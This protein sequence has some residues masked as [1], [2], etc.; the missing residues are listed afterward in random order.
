MNRQTSFQSCGQSGLPLAT[1][2]PDKLY[3]Y[4]LRRVW[5]SV[6]EPRVVTWVLLNPSTADEF[7]DDPTIRR[8]IG[9]SQT[10]HFDELMIVNAYAWRSTD[11]KGLRSP[12]C[13]A[14]GGPVGEGNDAAIAAAIDRSQL[15]VCGW[16]KHL[17]ADRRASLARLL[18]DRG[19]AD[20]E[21]T[22]LQLNSNGSPA[23]PLYLKGSLLPQPFVLET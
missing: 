7:A 10:W 14:A 21:L 15:V 9:F 13:V 20:V 2:S 18:D 16:G 8:C 19:L 5:R 11:P 23:H 6:D 4:T 22:A 12:E 3:R 1:W 17:Q